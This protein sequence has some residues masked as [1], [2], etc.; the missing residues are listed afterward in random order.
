MFDRPD[1]SDLLTAAQQELANKLLPGLDAEQRQVALRIVRA[2]GIVERS[3]ASSEQA[4]RAALQRMRA[5]GASLPALAE[6]LEHAADAERPL[7]AQL[8]AG[9]R[10]LKAAIRAGA[11]DDAPELQRELLHHLAASAEDRL[12][13]NNP[14]KLY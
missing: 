11:F 6:A 3:L 14:Q 10:A 5:L 1:A 2:L 12:R 9:E 13:V 8:D 4:G 7:H